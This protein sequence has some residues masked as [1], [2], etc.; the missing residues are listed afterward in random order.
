MLPKLEIQIIFLAMFHCPAS[1]AQRV[2]P[3]MQ[4][5]RVQ[6]YMIAHIKPL[7]VQPEPSH[8]LDPFTKL[9]V[10]E[11]YNSKNNSPNIPTKPEANLSRQVHH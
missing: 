7:R 8:T 1:P 11:F 10:E 2:E 6:P 4:P 5:L 3:V 9:W